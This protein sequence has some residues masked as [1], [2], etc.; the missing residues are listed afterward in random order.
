MVREV[1]IIVD[2]LRGFLEEGNPLYC[3]SPGREIIPAVIKLLEGKKGARRIYLCDNHAPDDP[4]FKMFAPH[5]IRGSRE[6]QVIPELAPY[7]GTVVP[8]TTLS[9]F[10]RTD[11]EKV[12]QELAPEKVTVAGVCTNICILYTVADLRVRGYAVEV[13]RDC[14]ATFD[15]EA[16]PFALAQMEKVFGAKLV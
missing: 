14:V 15:R 1:I 3:G 13:P 16:H 12:L 11:L 5:C 10:Y 9:G 6:A 7:P 8:K 2:M 4:E